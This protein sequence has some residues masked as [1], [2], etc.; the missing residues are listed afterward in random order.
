M[1]WELVVS[2]PILLI[3]HWF[4]KDTA[5]DAAKKAFL[6]NRIG[7]IGMFIGIMLFFTATG[8]FLFSDAYAGVAEGVFNQKLLTIAGLCLFAGAIGKSAQ[9]PLHVWLPDAMEGPTPVSALIH[10]AT[11]VAA[12][13]YLSVRL[14][15]IFS[16]D[17]L[18][19]IAYIGGFTA[20]FAAIIAVTQKRYQTSPRLFYLKPARLYDYGHR[21]RSLCS[22]LLPFGDARCIQGRTVSLQRQRHSR[23]ASRL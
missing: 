8:S 19:V 4:E 2:V 5:S 17:A 21:C 9:F 23:H 10:A 6:V 18:T 22:W 12:G 13:V 11:M 7:D 3:G 14:F 20:V 16:P 1:F 15:P